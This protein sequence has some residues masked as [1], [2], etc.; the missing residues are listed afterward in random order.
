MKCYLLK[1][2]LILFKKGVY[3]YVFLNVL[4]LQILNLLNLESLHMPHNLIF[5]DFSKQ[6]LAL[7]IS[8]ESGF[9]TSR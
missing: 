9:K 3:L 8:L 6:I 2:N 7:K 1:L 5:T 4:H